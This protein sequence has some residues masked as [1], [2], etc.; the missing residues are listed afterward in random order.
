MISDYTQHPRA[1]SSILIIA[2]KKKK[3]E[4]FCWAQLN[5]LWPYFRNSKTKKTYYTKINTG[6]VSRLGYCEQKDKREAWLRFRIWFS[7]F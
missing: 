6:L 4:P 2:K 5:F 7:T 3:L 1:H